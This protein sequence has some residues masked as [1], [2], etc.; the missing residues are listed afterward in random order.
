MYC[1]NCR[2][3]WRRARFCVLCG[4][5]L[6]RRSIEERTVDLHHVDWLLD[7]IKRWH[8]V[9][10]MVRLQLTQNYE[11][12]RALLQESL[13]EVESAPPVDEAPPAVDHSVLA[14]QPEQP[15]SEPAV[16]NTPG[17]E[18]PPAPADEP[19][20]SQQ[21]FAEPVPTV[22]DQVVEAASPW[23]RVWKPFLSESVGWFIGGF[24][25]LAGT[26]YLVRDAWGGLSDTSRAL[27]VFGLAGGWTLAFVTWARFLLRREHT[28]GAGAVLERI[29]AIIAPLA[30]VAVGPVVDHPL[31]F[32]PLLLGWS[33]VTARLAFAVARRVDERSGLAVA[34]A[35]GLVSVMMGAAP[36][37]SGFGANAVWFSL[38]P[39]GLCALA[40]REGPRETPRATSFVLVAMLY[41]TALFV[42]RVE[43]AMHASGVERSASTYAPMIALLASCVL[44]LRPRSARAADV[45]SVGAVSAQAVLLAPAFVGQAPAFV[46]AALIASWTTVRLALER[47]SKS[48]ARWLVPAY[49]F[50][51]LGFLRSDQ[52]V[53]G[54]VHDQL[55]TSVRALLGYQSAQVPPSY[56]SA[57]A[58][59]FV[60]AV[61]LFAARRFTREQGGRHLEADLLL[62]C[63]AVASIFFGCL[64]V[65]SLG[66]DVR[67]ALLA[68]PLLMSL[69]LGLGMGLRRR[70]LTLS[71]ALLSVAAALSYGWWLQSVWPL[72][73]VALGLAV[74]SIFSTRGHREMVSVA[75]GVLVGLTVAGSWATPLSWVQPLALALASVAALVVA[76][77]LDDRTALSFAWVVPFFCIART[78]FELGPTYA[79]LMLALAALAAAV[80]SRAT[81][82]LETGWVASSLAAFAAAWWSW[83]LPVHT[84]LTTPVAAAALLVGATVERR[85]ARATPFEALGLLLAT[86]CLV[87]PLES[88]VPGFYWM[89][90]ALS[91]PLGF[92]VALGCSVFAVRSGRCWQTTF[93]AS[94]V[95]LVAVLDVAVTLST[96]GADRISAD[97][98][99]LG[100]GAVILVSTPALVAAV[101]V[102]LTAMFWAWA[103][104]SWG[105]PVFVHQA[106]V[107]LAT[108]LSLLALFEEFDAT[109]K[110]ALNRSSVAWAASLS[111]LVVLILAF[112][113]TW[114]FGFILSAQVTVEP[115]RW[116]GIAG[117]ML[118]LVWVRATRS[119]IL[120]GAALLLTLDFAYTFQTSF[121]Y[122][123]PVA[124]VVLSR[125]TDLALV[126]RALKLDQP[127]LGAPFLIAAVVTAAVT[128]GL[129]QTHSSEVGWP[130]AWAV[131]LLVM[132]DHALPARLIAAVLVTLT[133]PLMWPAAAL[134]LVVL[135]FALRRGE[136]RVARFFGAESVGVSASVAVVSAV[137]IAAVNVAVHTGAE[138]QFILALT[139]AAAAVLFDWV[140]GL[141]IGIGALGFNLHGLGYGLGPVLTP[142]AFEV[143]MTFAGGAAALRIRWVAQRLGKAWAWLGKGT[144]RDLA[145]PTWAGAFAIAVA[146]LTTSSPLWLFTIALLLMT[147]DHIEASLALVL[148]AVMVVRFVPTE[149]AGVVFAV[150]GCVLTWSA[151]VFERR[152][153]VLR[154][155]HHAGWVMSWV[156]LGFC[157]DMHSSQ[158][159]QVWALMAV[160]MWAVAKR[161]PKVEFVGFAATWCAAHAVMAHV[162]VV[163]STG[164]PRELI[165]SWFSLVSMLVAAWPL[166]RGFTLQRRMVGLVL[167]VV[168]VFELLA[169]L[170]VLDGPHPRE[171]LVGV[172][173]MGILA[174]LLA[175]RAWADETRESSAAAGLA[176]AAL[177]TGVVAVHHLWLGYPIGVFETWA[178]VGFGFALGELGARV[179]GRV[180]SALRVGAFV[181]PVVGVLALAGQPPAFVSW[182]LMAVGAHFAIMARSTEVRR[183]ASVAAAVAFN[184]AMVFGYQ[185]TGWGGLHYVAI[186]FGV[187]MLTLTWVFK[188]SLEAVT[189]ARLRAVAV[190]L[191]YAAAAWKPLTFDAAWALWLCVLVCVIGVAAGIVLRI[192]SYVFLG[193]AF[194]VTSVVANLVRYG[195]REPRA[196]AIFLSALG[197]LV[198]GF[199]VLVTTKR[200]E[201]L[202]RYRLVQQL[203]A[204]WEA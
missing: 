186:P 87:P 140:P 10:P 122:V 143:A 15:V 132:R 202:A 157:T 22:D 160:S 89:T 48:S 68:T 42:I 30:T 189:A 1:V 70:E 191:I 150:A 43:V 108:G 17:V 176:Q 100:V 110:F 151:V 138:A 184:V 137:A 88:V 16:E 127:A 131:A 203:L 201:L 25:I 19:A 126:R 99:M 79:P 96:H 135:A 86:L 152:F 175:R 97:V 94:L 125:S 11:A 155:W 146:S 59:V 196:G 112:S 119:T 106:L 58:A 204:R 7:E 83:A 161:K 128:C 23:H 178:C 113:A 55:L 64:A 44:W 101:T 53:P 63:T 26:L 98:L 197:L 18:S 67:P 47:V 78:A 6:I 124:A 147:P 148:G 169:C 104:V 90:P 190:T 80:A 14:H 65:W 192:R 139:I 165:M 180:T 72:A 164:A 179:Q 2:R 93:I 103:S 81:S 8:T 24:L 36:M 82:R 168:S 117:L 4:H 91:V 183:W 136:G 111:A 29:A 9:E 172:I 156:A 114:N 171:A 170:L 200:A 73:V 158:F 40:W 123:P 27:T 60:V 34:A 49:V 121:F 69:G 35:M 105:L 74:W 37:L 134:T 109:W 50:G 54:V 39:V 84:G 120:S 193:T 185:A 173:T 92:C 76:R 163:L 32:W 141:A 116:W 33:A 38:L 130:L 129:A 177:M 182:V 66:N 57:Y 195:I 28:Q 144:A 62:W 85:R 181:W 194:L 153:S 187:S 115:G 142:F 41:A 46:L 149:T 118:P 198:V 21:I 102:P 145:A 159:A 3:E 56:V 167:G 13:G 12:R 52:L 162:G 133:V 199:M 188:E 61:G 75:C 77:N 5:P 31:L 107:V 45:W 71:G 154:M 174:L 20:S 51:Y 95:S 166:A